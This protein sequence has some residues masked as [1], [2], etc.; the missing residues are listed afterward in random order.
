MKKVTHDGETRPTGINVACSIGDKFHV[1][2]F[3][4]QIFQILQTR[5]D[6]R[7]VDVTP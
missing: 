6:H 4:A 5:R 1:D 7:G 3:L 2:T